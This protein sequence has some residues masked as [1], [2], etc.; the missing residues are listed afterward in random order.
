VYASTLFCE[1][2]RLLCLVLGRT[3]LSALVEV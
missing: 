1:L 2:N 3:W